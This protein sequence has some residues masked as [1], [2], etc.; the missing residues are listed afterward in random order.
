MASTRLINDNP[1]VVAG[2]VRA[3]N[4]AFREGSP[5]RPPRRAR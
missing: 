4:R 2:F 5:T 3:F 1:K